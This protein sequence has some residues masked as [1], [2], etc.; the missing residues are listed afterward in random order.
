MIY[1]VF[2]C[3]LWR[4][5]F[6]VMEFRNS[7][8][9]SELI[10]GWIEGLIVIM[11]GGL[12]CFHKFW[13]QKDIILGDS[14]EFFW[15]FI[16]NLPLSYLL[17]RVDWLVW[18]KCEELGL[19]IGGYMVR[20]LSVDWYAEVQRGFRVYTFYRFW[21]WCL[22]ELTWIKVEILFVWVRWCFRLLKD[23]FSGRASLMYM[24]K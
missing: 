14:V 11:T 19:S 20:E 7:K 15:T 5:T 21:M 6:S 9:V 8:V 10:K 1:V 4:W 17:N 13:Q 18:A 22:K 12:V 23:R 16:L 3:N 2:F 24:E